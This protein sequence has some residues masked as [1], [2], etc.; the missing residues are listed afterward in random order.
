LNTERRAVSM[1]I[2]HGKLENENKG[3][4]GL[5]EKRRIKQH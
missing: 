3:A 5:E 2:L 1:K 4:R